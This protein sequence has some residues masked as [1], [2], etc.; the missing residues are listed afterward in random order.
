MDFAASSACLNASGVARL[1]TGAPAR[2]AIPM[3]TLASRT[4]LSGLTV[5]SRSKPSMAGS[6]AITASNTSPSLIFCVTTAGEPTVKITRW[7]LSLPKSAARPRTAFCTAPTLSTRMSA[8]AAGSAGEAMPASE[9][10]TA[11]MGASGPN[12]RIVSSPWKCQTILRPIAA[13]LHHVRPR[14]AR[15][16]FAPHRHRADVRGGGVLRHARYDGQISQSL[17]EHAPGGVGALHRRIRVPVHRVESM[18]AARPHAH[19]PPAAAARTL[20]A[21][22]RIDPG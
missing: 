3:P 4:R 10:S 18:D 14:I 5:P 17:Y 21:A 13:I 9:S 7:P 2:T 12:L 19:E 16:R 8:A 20:G 15:A 1:G 22:A 11:A 6:E